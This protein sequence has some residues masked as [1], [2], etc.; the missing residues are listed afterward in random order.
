M[1]LSFKDIYRPGVKYTRFLSVI[2]LYGIAY[3]LY[4]GIQDNYLAELVHITSFERGVVEF[5][6]EIPGLLVVLIF[7]LMYRLSEN[8]VFKIGVIFLTV[9]LGS[10]LLVGTGK[11]QVII[12]M[13]LFSMGEHIVLPLRS[14][15]SMHLAKKETGGRALGV[16]GAM[17]QAGRITGFILVSALFFIFAKLGYSRNDSLFFRVVFALSFAI[18]AA[19]L[20]VVLPM[21]ESTEKVQ[22]R[23]FY[24]AKK[25]SKFY[26]LEVFYGARKQ[27]FLTFAPYVLI[28]QYG[29][30]AS[31][32]SL[33]MA[34]SA[35]FGIVFNP[36][37][38]KL[39]D[40]VG[41]KIIMVSDTLILVVVCFFYGFAHRIFPRDIAFMVVCA[42]YVLD[43]I[44]SLASMA[45]NVYVQ[46]IASSQEEVTATLSTGI[47]V[48][49]VISIFIALMGGWIWKV[50]GIEVLFTISAFLGLLNSVYAATIKKPV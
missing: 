49:H 13:V 42:N 4:R 34:V 32:I 21:E 26:M 18:M 10:F 11:V 48:N 47:S 16:T 46:D 39:I 24:F 5:F 45:T 20:V 7:A 1:K 43:A 3:G 40:K 27:V 36:L 9:G 2:L 6:R 25:F 29:A 31:V 33:L 12:V 50:T 17:D 35:A 8:R 28:L 37:I 19:A 14:T 23:R 15:V 44:I 41:Y 30:D 38:G 22:R